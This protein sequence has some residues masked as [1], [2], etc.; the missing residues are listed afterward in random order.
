MTQFVYI[1]S[2]RAP[3]SQLLRVCVGPPSSPAYQG[4]VNIS[5]DPLPCHLQNGADVTG[6]IIQYIHLSTGEATN[7]SS[8][9]TRLICRQETGGPY[10]CVVPASSFIVNVAYNFRVAARNNFGVS[11]FSNPVIF[12]ISSLG[13]HTI[14]MLTITDQD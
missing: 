1:G 9:S 8:S 10:S 14:L 2:K 3:S 13:R 6:Y 7:I 11:S 12:T 4:R 5:W